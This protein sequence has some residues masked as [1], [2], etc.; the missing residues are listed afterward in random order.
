MYLKPSIYSCVCIELQ[1][2]TMY[3]HTYTT[4]GDSICKDILFIVLV[5]Y[6]YLGHQ[7]AFV[8]PHPI[9]GYE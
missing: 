5:F 1:L 3:V 8:C 6:Y 7:R 9:C 4:Q 2:E